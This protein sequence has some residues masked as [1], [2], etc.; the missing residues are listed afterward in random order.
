M[1]RAIGADYYN[2]DEAAQRFR[3]EIPSLTATQANAAA[4]G[5][6]RQLLEKAITEGLDFNFETTLGGNT[7]TRLLEKAV[8]KGFEVRVW[9]VGLAGVDL[10]L[11]RV[12]SRVEHGGHDI[13]DEKIRERYDASRRNLI[14]LLPRLRELRVYDNSRDADPVAGVAPEP[15]LIVHTERGKIVSSCNRASTPEWAKPIFAAVL[16]LDPTN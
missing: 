15:V 5:K 11:A 13:P 9:Y 8:D 1:L 3:T 12:R 6:G 14:R 10:H 2:P 4:W 16:K 7:L